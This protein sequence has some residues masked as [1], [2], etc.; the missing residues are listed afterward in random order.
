M[1]LGAKS[2]F[3]DT[4]KYSLD[5][6]VTYDAMQALQ[7]FVNDFPYSDYTEE[8][9]KM[10][11]ELQFKL[12]KKAFEIATQYYKIGYFN[13]A[14]TALENFNSEFLGSSF[15]EEATF[16]KFK[17]GYELGVRSS[18]AKKAK[19]IDDAIRI[20]EKFAKKFQSQNSKKEASDLHE[21]LLLEKT[22]L[23]S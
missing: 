9:N 8:V 15:K 14:I 22:T 17:A 5:Q 23:N 13:S 2:K 21:K 7:E 11:A 16:I 3:L 20:Y 4:P 6:T 12:E 18:I 19:R 1:F 10:T